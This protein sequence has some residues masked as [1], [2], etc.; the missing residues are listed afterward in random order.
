M[1][2]RHRRSLIRQLEGWTALYRWSHASANLSP[3]ARKRLA[4]FDYYRESKNVAKTCRHF[5]IAR[6]TF[7]IWKKRY[8]AHNLAALE[9]RFCTPRRRRHRDITVEQE[10]RIVA[11]RRRYIRY[12]SRKIA[13]L[14]RAEHG[15]AITAWKVQ[16]T[17]EKYQ[18]YYRPARHARLL[19]R[20]RAAQK[21]KRITELRKKRVAGF[22]ICLDTIVLYWGGLKRYIFTAIDSVSKLAL[23]RMYTTKSSYNGA[24]FLTRLVL[25]LDGK[26]ENVGH[27]NG[28]EFLKYFSAACAKLGIPQYFS[29]PRTP[30]DNA[31]NERFNQT[32]KHEFLALGN[33]TAEPVAFNRRL[34]DW[35]V[36]Y[37][38]RRPHQSLGYVPPINYEAKYLKVL[39][40]YPSRTAP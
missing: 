37:N 35:L 40:M 30:K 12:G 8:D 9:S 33:F 29:R 13:W 38:F 1:S 31:V 19:A 20:R 4:W 27:D 23:A 17:I 24:D 11:L 18:L 14:Y 34:T 28:A 6:K 21:R 39:P 26:I 25:L 2:V 3:E 5:G 36:E 7:Y 15:E 16:K 32:L 10:M 22:L